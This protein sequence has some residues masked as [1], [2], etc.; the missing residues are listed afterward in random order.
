[1][2]GFFPLLFIVLLV[3]KLTEHITT[4]WFWVSAALWMPSVVG[5]AL[6]VVG[7]TVTL[8]AGGQDRR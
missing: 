5:L 8:A 6:F 2:I 1:M 4:S 7:C 3:L